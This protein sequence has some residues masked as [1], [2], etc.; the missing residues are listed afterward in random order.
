[1]FIKPVRVFL[2]ISVIGITLVSINMLIPK[3]GVIIGDVVIIKRLTFLPNL[4]KED[5]EIEKDTL[6]MFKKNLSD[7]ITTEISDESDILKEA[8]KPDSA[9]IYDRNNLYF[10]ETGRKSLVKFFESIDQIK[11]RPE[12]LHILHIGDSQLDGDR[13]TRFLRA[14]FQNQYGGK[15]CGFV[16]SLDKTKQ[17]FSIWIDA[18]G[19]WTQ[20]WNY[21]NLKRDTNSSFGLLGN[22]VN[23]AGTNNL[24][25]QL[26]P[27]RVGGNK[28]NSFV[29]AK[30]YLSPTVSNQTI[31]CMADGAKFQT[32]TLIESKEIKTITY[33]LPYAPQELDFRFS[34]AKSPAIH[35]ILLDG[36]TGVQVD[37]IAFRGQ[38]FTRYIQNDSS[39]VKSM[40]NDVDVGL[41]ILQFGANLLPNEATDFSFYKKIMRRQ[42]SLLN[43]FMPN[44]PI[45]VVGVGDAAE[46]R[47]G[48]L[49]TRKSV[50]PIIKAQKE[51]SVEMNAI[52]LNLFQ[53]MG[54]S[55]TMVKWST[56]EPKKA[57][58]DYLHFNQKGGEEVANLVYESINNEYILWHNKDK[59]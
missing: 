24:S 37:N 15:G 8:I 45:V 49:Q 7:T 20:E 17:N 13:I 36:E 54:G 47:D 55:G 12:P 1:M 34:G 29:V 53:A 59:K 46:M 11:K 30:I 28:G 18:K 35:G 23:G 56:Q 51:G 9:A 10:S 3:E 19:D 42:I 5:L 50:E 58:S 57:M 14:R 41:I 52:F 2:L 4:G 43:K 26:Y 39:L 38:L 44:V 31:V 21:V 6:L 25:L 48:L 27:A 32:D 33:Q 22:V 40:V 16:S